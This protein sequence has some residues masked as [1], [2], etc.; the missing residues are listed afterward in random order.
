MQCPWQNSFIA[1]VFCVCAVSGTCWRWS[2]RLIIKCLSLRIWV[3]K[4]SLMVGVRKV[5]FRT[6]ILWFQ[7]VLNARKATWSQPW[8][9]TIGHMRQ[10][11]AVKTKA[12]LPRTVLWQRGGLPLCWASSMKRLNSANLDFEKQLVISARYCSF[13]KLQFKCTLLIMAALYNR[14]GWMSTILWH[15]VW[16]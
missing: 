7:T 10:Q 8:D 9:R 6:G 1:C 11:K 4:R 12:V 2:C 13:V 5:T 14:A 3:T 16:P 15:M